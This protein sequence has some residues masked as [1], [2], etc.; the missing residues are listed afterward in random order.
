MRYD[1]MALRERN[2]EGSRVRLLVL[3]GRSVERGVN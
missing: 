1:R 2:E 3:E